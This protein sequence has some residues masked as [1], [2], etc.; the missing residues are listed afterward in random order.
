[1]SIYQAYKAAKE[2]WLKT[3]PSASPEQIEQAFKDIAR[4]LGF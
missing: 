1:M 3:N 4:K 2:E